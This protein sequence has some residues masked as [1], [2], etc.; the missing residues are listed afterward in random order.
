ML[1]P[2][3]SMK[4]LTP[5]ELKVYFLEGISPSSEDLAD[6]A[7]ARHLGLTMV[8]YLKVKAKGAAQDT[9]TAAAPIRGGAGSVGRGAATKK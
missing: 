6:A 7:A 3:E 2:P 4:I 1:V 9:A 5:A 8:E